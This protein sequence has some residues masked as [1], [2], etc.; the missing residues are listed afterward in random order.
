MKSLIID[1]EPT[2]CE[3][4]SSV[5]AMN[6]ISYESYQDPVE[7]LPAIED[8]CFD[9]AFIDIGLPSM[10]GLE[11]GKR[12]KEKCPD[13][14]VVFVTGVGDYDQ[15][16]RAI[17]IG[18]YD[19]VR[20]PFRLSEI[21]VCVARLVEKRRL[22]DSDRCR[23][24]PEFAN[25]MSM[26]LMHELRNPLTAIGGFS[27]RAYTADGGQDK[28]RNYAKIIF[29]QSLRAEKALNDVLAHLKADARQRT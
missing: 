13:S 4:V 21:Q 26:E 18:A 25:E 24:V 17:K 5:L 9:F 12:F 16:I 6:H 1:D 10:D 20:K 23:Q 15:A 2:L 11:F 14:D 7:A 27:K 3:I 28:L 29:D 22:Y 19:F 8:N